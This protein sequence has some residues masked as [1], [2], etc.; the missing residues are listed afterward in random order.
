MRVSHAKCVRVG[1]SGDAFIPSSYCSHARLTLILS[2][3]WRLNNFICLIRFFYSF[4]KLCFQDGDE[5]LK[6]AHILLKIAQKWHLS[7]V[8]K[9]C[10]LK[11]YLLKLSNQ[12]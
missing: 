6:I 9:A 5:R 3:S 12:E 1:R 11:V 10:N 4:T 8:Q 2:F 7:Q